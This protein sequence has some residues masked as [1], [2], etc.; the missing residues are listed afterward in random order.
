[1]LGLKIE[2]RRALENVEAST[3]VPGIAFAEWGPSDMGM[4]FGSPPPHDAPYPEHMAN[5]RARVKAA[6]DAVNIAFLN[7]MAPDDITEMIDEGVMI[8]AG[9]EESA[10]IG[11]EYTKRTMP[12]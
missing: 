3:G 9:G 11:R 1:M 2:N 12:V 6:C 7:R 4:S 8:G 5:A 10:I